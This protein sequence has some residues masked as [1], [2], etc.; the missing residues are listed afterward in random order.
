MLERKQQI[1]Q[2]RFD[3]GRTPTLELECLNKKLK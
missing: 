2:E 1:I 3:T